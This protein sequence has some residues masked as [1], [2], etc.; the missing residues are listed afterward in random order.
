MNDWIPA[1]Q[2]TAIC[3]S[4]LWFVLA[5]ATRP[6]SPL[7]IVW[8]LF[9][10]SIA[11]AMARSLVGVEAGH[12]YQILGVGA[13]L[14]CNGFWLVARALFRGGRPFGTPHLVYAGIVAALII[15]TQQE[16]LV[17]DAFMVVS[18]EMLQ[19]LSSVVL[20]LAFWEGLRGWGQHHG[21]ERSMR[22]AFMATYGGSVAA[23]FIAPV[24]DPAGT[25]GI[26]AIASATAASAILLVTQCLVTWR[27]RHPLGV[28][29]RSGASAAPH[30]NAV[31]P[32]GP[33]RSPS[34][35]AETDAATRAEDAAL[36][37]MLERYMRLEKPYLRTELKLN[38]LAQALAVSEYRI[39][40]AV[41]GTLGHR[42]IN[43]YINRYRLDHA[44][45]LLADPAFGHWSTLVVGLESGF[46]SLGAFHRAFKTA[47]GC[48]PGEYRA[49]SL[50]PDAEPA[51]ANSTPLRP[52]LR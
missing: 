52:A 1:L 24:L 16:A 46:G 22:L 25:G 50:P 13:C 18:S 9:C 38:Q 21:L 12:W 4:L 34:A 28:P 41:R 33:R 20:V 39:S 8:A 5:V 35:P 30:P 10:A 42:N 26:H 44:R 17:P 2:A 31:E 15:T 19:L 49:V 47:E 37:K 36:A 48:T 51:L 40:R 14:T 11:M 27:L 23:C 32:T 3:L 45:D 7:S 29:A 6:R 43:H